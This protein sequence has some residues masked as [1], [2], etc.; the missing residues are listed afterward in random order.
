MSANTQQ[1]GPFHTTHG[2]DTEDPACP[3]CQAFGKPDALFLFTGR[4]LDH[5]LQDGGSQSWRV[6]PASVRA[7]RY[8]VCFQNRYPPTNDGFYDGAVEHGTA[9]VVAKIAGLAPPTPDNVARD[10]YERVSGPRYLVRFS[11]Y[12]KLN[13]PNAWQHWRNPVIYGSLGSFGIDPNRCSFRPMPSP[14]ADSATQPVPPL[15]N[16]GAVARDAL[17]MPMKMTIP[18]AKRALAAT[19]GVDPEAIEITIRG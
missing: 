16:S 19:F 11:E 4:S 9:F 8:V 12:A 15:P 5:L 6:S 7:V 13:L 2:L 17:S 3:A 10:H 18:E 14:P 1:Y